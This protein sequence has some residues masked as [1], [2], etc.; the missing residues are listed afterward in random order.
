MMHFATSR[1]IGDGLP[2]PPRSMQPLLTKNSD[3]YDS[4]STPIH[5]SQHNSSWT[6]MQPNY[7]RT[8][9]HIAPSFN[10]ATSEERWEACRYWNGRWCLWPIPTPPYHQ[11]T[12]PRQPRSLRCTAG[13]QTV[14][15]VEAAI[16]ETDPHLRLTN[17]LGATVLMVTGPTIAQTERHQATTMETVEV[18]VD[19]EEICGR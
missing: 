10:T 7:D 11:R 18:V 15:E 8:R 16:K 3:D 19:E 2:A 4:N 12:K 17:V 14:T 5:R 6:N 13:T 9:W 1:T